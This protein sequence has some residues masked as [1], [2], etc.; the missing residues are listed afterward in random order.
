MNVRTS[1]GG[2]L[3]QFTMELLQNNSHL[4]RFARREALLIDYAGNTGH[5]MD[6]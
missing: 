5:L 4:F 3:S 1:V 2:A 6:H